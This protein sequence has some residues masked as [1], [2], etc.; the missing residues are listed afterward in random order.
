[1]NRFRWAVPIVLGALTGCSDP[2]PAED[3]ESGTTASESESETGDTGETE[4]GDDEPDYEIGLLDL[5]CPFPIPADRS[6]DC[7]TLVVPL[8]RTQLDAGV[9]SLP[10]A[11]LHPA[12][13]ASRP[14][15]VYFHGGPGG[16]AF[17]SADV[18][19]DRIASHDGDLVLFDQ[20]GGGL[21]TPSLD[22]PEVEAGWFA[23]FAAT[24]TPEEELAITAGAYEQCRARLVQETDLSMF[25]TEAIADDADDLRRA[26]GYETW[27]LY[28]IS[29]G[30]RVGL[31]VMRRH[32]AHVHNAV[33]DSV[34][35]PQVGGV[36]WMIDSS[37]EA[38]ERL[39]AGC[40]AE[41]LCSFTFPDLAADLDTAVANLDANPYPLTIDDSQG[42]SH[43]LSLTGAD[44]YAG[45]FNALYDVELIPVVPLLIFQAA[46]GNLNFLVDLANQ[47]I[48]FLTGLS[49]GAR[50]SV[51]CVD[52]GAL[53]DQAELAAAISDNPTFST[54]I[55]AYSPAY[56][57]MWNVEPAPAEFL[58]AVESEVPT[59][60]L[61][62]E[63]D[64]VTPVSQT[65]LAAATIVGSQTYVFP[66]F[67][68]GVSRQSP[69][70]EQMTREFLRD[71][72]A[73]SS[74]WSALPQDTF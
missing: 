54:M 32:G 69:C 29:Y 8:D 46:Q 3:G 53:I 41:N 26:L 64:P 22:C 27:G 63:F 16:S 18:W 28:G 34:Y 48:P 15:V 14:P 47:S 49:E 70:A 58:A 21:A 52:G 38:L 4:T 36:A 73:D 44:F 72:M 56:C 5:A 12:G 62:G 20:R 2:A 39:I 30:T 33:L 50:L 19:F 35:P 42:M 60:L 40:L 68:H 1:M 13:A 31:E 17:A 7:Y 9:V 24:G 51:D 23:A 37:R 59:L 71:S 66:G 6:A 43:D 74:C 25:N 65:E 10:V 55:G 61:A 45:M 11:V 67:G 57:A